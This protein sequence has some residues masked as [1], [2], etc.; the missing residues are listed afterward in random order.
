LDKNL[1]PNTRILIA[2]APV[3]VLPSGP[4]EG[5]TGTDAGI[6]IPALT[7]RNTLLA[8]FGINFLAESTLEQVCQEQVKYIYV[9]KMDQSFVA[10]QLDEKPAWYQRRL[11]L[12]GAQLYQLKGCS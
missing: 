5:L 10:T 9:G 2:G 3:N 11:F 8:P 4:S 12:P 6:W 7:G 1:S